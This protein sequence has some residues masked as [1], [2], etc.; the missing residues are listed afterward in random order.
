MSDINDSLGNPILERPD[1]PMFKYRDHVVYSNYAHNLWKPKSTRIR[2]ADI[3]DAMEM[4]GLLMR[5]HEL[6][7]YRHSIEKNLLLFPYM[8]KKPES[9]QKLRNTVTGEIYTIEQAIV[10]P[11]AMRW[12]GVVKISS[13]TPPDPTKGER[14]EFV[15]TDGLVEFTSEFPI[16]NVVDGQDEEGM[17][18]DGGPI[19]PTITYS[20]FRQ[21]PGS[22]GKAPFAPAKNYKPEVR[23]ILKS[24]KTPGHSIEILGQYFDSIIEFNCWATDNRS[25]DSLADW[26]QRFMT[27]YIK[28]LKLNGVVEVLFWQ[29]LRDAAVTKWR[30]D[31]ISR[32]LQYFFR[33]ESLI[34]VV[35]RDISNIDITMGVEDE[36]VDTRERWVAGQLVTGKLT[37]EQYESMFVDTSGNYLFGNFVLNDGNL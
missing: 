18:E 1:D 27:Q 30:Q 19:R 36:I 31:L 25:A 10:N 8:F 15:G 32:T 3:N 28:V 33:T 26:F 11:V 24:T 22:I 16:A 9:G 4:I 29:R 13:Q 35:L 34:P 14:L 6:T 2:S 23:E 12:E 5:L 17:L 21:E 20:L 37:Q 7:Y